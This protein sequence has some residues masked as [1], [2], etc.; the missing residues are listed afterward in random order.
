MEAI[1]AINTRRSIRKYLDKPVEQEKIDVIIEAG[2]KAP[3]AKNT[4]NTII[5]RVKDPEAN[6]QIRKLNNEIW[7]KAEGVDPFYGAPEILVVLGKKD[8]EKKVYDGSCVL[9]NMMIAAHA[10]DLG[11][12]WIHRAKETFETDWGKE[13]LKKAGVEGEYEGIGHLALGYPAVDNP[14]AP[15]CKGQR[16]Y[17]I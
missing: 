9:E 3:S 6:A 4:Q 16:A 15:G 7:G 1:Q 12:C 14:P 13:L 10:L 8:W 11:T 2:L 17:T 5:L